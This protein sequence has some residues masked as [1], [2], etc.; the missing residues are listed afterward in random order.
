MCEVIFGHLVL[1]RIS[2]ALLIKMYDSADVLSISCTV[3]RLTGTYYYD[4]LIFYAKFNSSQ[5]TILKER[6]KQDS[7]EGGGLQIIEMGTNIQTDRQTGEGKWR[8]LKLTERVHQ[9]AT[10]N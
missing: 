9:P 1:L 6:P 7:N 2:Q 10:S 3:F 8:Y 4:S 5:N